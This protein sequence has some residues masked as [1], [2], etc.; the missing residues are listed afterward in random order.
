VFAL[1]HA[2]V[3]CTDKF[4]FAG[5][6]FHHARPNKNGLIHLQVQFLMPFVTHLHFKILVRI[7]SDQIQPDDRP[8][9]V[10]MPDNRLIICLFSFLLAAMAVLGMVFFQ[11]K[12]MFFCSFNLRNFGLVHGNLEQ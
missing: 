4:F 10:Q 11:W 8:H 2:S 6:H 12:A 3:A 9:G 5:K 1:A 7:G